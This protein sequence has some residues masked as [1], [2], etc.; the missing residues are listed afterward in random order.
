[1]SKRDCLVCQCCKATLT[2]NSSGEGH[3]A[4][5]N[6]KCPK[7]ADIYFCFTED[8]SG[9]S[10]RAQ[11]ATA[12]A[13][14]CGWGY[15]GK[16]LDLGQAPTM[17]SPSFADIPGVQSPWK[18]SEYVV[19]RMISLVSMLLSTA[20]S[21][22]IPSL[23]LRGLL[24]GQA[25]SR[26]VILPGDWSAA[27]LE[28]LQQQ[29]Q[30]L[31]RHLRSSNGRTSAAKAMWLQSE[32]AKALSNAVSWLLHCEETHQNSDVATQSEKLMRA[33]LVIALSG[34]SASSL[35]PAASQSAVDAHTAVATASAASPII[36]STA[37]TSLTAARAVCCHLCGRAVSLNT[38]AELELLSQHRYFCTVINAQSE[39]PTWLS[40]ST[41]NIQSVIENSAEK[42]TS[43]V[44]GW[45]CNLKA[46]TSI[47]HNEPAHQN[48][49]TT[50]VLSAE[51]EK[52][53]ASPG[54]KHAL[55]AS[56]AESSASSMN[57][58]TSNGCG[59]V[60][61]EQVYKRIRS[62]LAMAAANRS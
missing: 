43:V 58:N 17:C 9:E 61:P 53:L 23:S 11:L 55:T 5:I 7:K 25:G 40:L 35:A 10:L 62:V 27:E 44:L 54:Q 26:Q 48:E 52:A 42:K 28:S 60:S 33:L 46:V 8:A 29:L 38:S 14:G 16:E 49:A 37:A 36:G 6:E 1:M 31:E 4:F 51:Q 18:L 22:N 57:S 12:H 24:T 32:G 20:S 41:T 3:P 39:V 19:T 59:D 15:S 13:V 56:V 45:E 47:F 34:W 21:T 2:H 30:D 50:P